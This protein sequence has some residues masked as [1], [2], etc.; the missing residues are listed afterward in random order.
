MTVSATTAYGIHTLATNNIDRINFQR[1][2]K[3][4]VKDDAKAP[5]MAY[6]ERSGSQ[7]SS[8]SDL[9]KLFS[10]DLMSR[11]YTLTDDTPAG[12]VAGST[13]ADQTISSVAN[14]VTGMIGL[15]HGGIASEGNVAGTLIYISDVDSA[16]TEINYTNLSGGTIADNDVLIPIA[17]ASADD[18]TTGPTFTDR[19]PETI[20]GYL[21]I[22]KMN[23]TITI[24]ERDTEVYA[25]EGREQEKIKRSR[26]EFMRSRELH[27]WFSRATT[28]VGSN[29]IHTSMGI[30]EQLAAG[31]TWIDAGAAA[32]ADFM[33]GNALAAGAAF[34]NTTTF[35]CFHGY[36][37]LAGLFKLGAGKLQ[38]FV[39]DDEYGFKGTQS[40]RVAQYTLR[41]VHSQAFDIVG[42][43][44]D[45]NFI[46]LDLSA[47]TNWYMN[48]EGK[49]QL[50]RDT[51]PKSAKQGETVVHMWR[52]HEGI[53]ITQPTRHFGITELI[54]PT[55]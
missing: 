6:Y 47:V 7:K 46:G 29:K 19:E 24:T 2:D 21:S 27:A 17:F 25:A 44:F 13:A 18:A 16:N 49:M 22:L 15:V 40:I 34:Y 31:I 38:T 14:L 37:A 42:A 4:D 35:T 52:V 54:S 30:H 55:S 51:D 12:T 26:M 32:L 28:N 41:T 20:T 8:Q 50:K 45:A 23:V 5:L 11:R 53:T 1:A 33:L 3:I 39:Q 48:G 9:I 36:K 10:V 43:P